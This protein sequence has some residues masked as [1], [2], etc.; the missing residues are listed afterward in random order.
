MKAWLRGHSPAL[1]QSGHRAL[2]S[3]HLT[4]AAATGASVPGTL[5]GAAVP[6]VPRASRCLRSLASCSAVGFAS[7]ATGLVSEGFR[8]KSVGGPTHRLHERRHS[9]CI[10]LRLRSHSPAL[11]H[12]KQLSDLSSHGAA[13]AAA[14][15]ALAGDCTS[16]MN[17][18]SGALPS[19]P[20][21]PSLPQRSQLFLQC[22]RMKPGF[23]V[24]S[25]SL[26]HAA[27]SSA[28]LRSTHPG[29]AFLPYFS[30]SVRPS[31]PAA[32]APAGAGLVS[33]TATLGLAS[34]GADAA[35]FSMASSSFLDASAIA[36]FSTAL[37]AASLLLPA[38]SPAVGWGAVLLGMSR[39]ADPSPSPRPLGVASAGTRRSVWT[40]VMAGVLSPLLLHSRP[41]T[42]RRHATAPQATAGLFDLLPSLRASEFDMGSSD[43]FFSGVNVSEMLRRIISDSFRQ[44]TL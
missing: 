19:L 40:D 44:R 17:F 9:A 18:F 43:K 31:A 3:V 20:S 23:L 34:L 6:V 24:H 5:G 42:R 37:R 13:A 2:L 10:N 26:D 33:R 16:S 22:A 29:C 11:V 8:N 25:P 4:V 7:S 12:A 32:S 36:L 1:A 38:L 41:A 39:S 35:Y 14:A 30:K 28:G 15:A 21:L 27:H